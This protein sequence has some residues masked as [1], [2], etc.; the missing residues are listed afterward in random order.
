VTEAEIWGAISVA[1]HFFAPEGG[2]QFSVPAVILANIIS[3]A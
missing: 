2:A 1:P 3:S